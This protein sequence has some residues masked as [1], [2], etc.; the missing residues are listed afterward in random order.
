LNILLFG[1][2]GAGKGTQSAFLVEE[3]GMTHVSTGDL[4]R[5]NIKGET[6]LGKQV[7][8][9]IANGDL[10]PD[11][12]VVEMVENKVGEIDNFILDGFPRTMPQAEALEKMLV[13]NNIS[14]DKAVFLEV[15]DESL[16]KRL[17]GRRVCESCGSV[18]HI[19]GK[20][21]KK[22]GICDQCGS[23]LIQREDDMEEAIKHRLEVYAENTKP[24]KGFYES[25]GRLVQVEGQG[26]SKEV[27]KRIK[28][29]MGS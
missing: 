14:L 7:K 29:A 23:A 4:F 18:F 28:E 1:P 26:D 27:F 5:A 2:P 17:S 3:L 25:N 8:G 10:V 12:I 15:P 24:L 19:T 11:S 13:A 16:V 6:E 20:P 22:E 9:I 21:P